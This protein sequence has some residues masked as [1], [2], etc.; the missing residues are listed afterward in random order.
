[1]STVSE[2]LHTQWPVQLTAGWSRGK[3]TNECELPLSIDWWPAQLSICR[4]QNSAEPCTSGGQVESAWSRLG[5]G[6]G[7]VGGGSHNT[8]VDVLIPVRPVVA[9]DC[10]TSLSISLYHWV[11][12]DES[13]S[14]DLYRWVSV[15]ESY[16]DSLSLNLYLWISISLFTSLYLWVY[17]F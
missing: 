9:A 10:Y 3:P 7:R 4:R 2:R 8:Q 15:T 6:G 5:G 12:I 11:S 14:L 1:M 17:L 13:L 16:S